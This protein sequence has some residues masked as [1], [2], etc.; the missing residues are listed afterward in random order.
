MSENIALSPN[1]PNRIV[2]IFGSSRPK[3]DSPEYQEAELLG[4]KLS[5][6]GLSVCTGGYRG[7]MEAVS[8]GA[9]RVE[10]NIIGV[11]SAVFSPTPNEYVNMQVHTMTLYERLQ[12]L[13]ELGSGYIILKG[14]TGTLVELALVWELMN[15]NM[16]S[17]KPI[18]VVT[19]FWKPVVDLLDTEL[20]YEGLE[21]CTKYVKIARDA[22]EAAD[23]MIEALPVRN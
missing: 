2:S 14:G 23:M 15:K 18:I 4:R 11:T 5:E 6:A 16:I 7:I 3:E 8:K 12:K 10:G 20:A 19:D 17:E 21:S 9:S 22:S 13:I 1:K